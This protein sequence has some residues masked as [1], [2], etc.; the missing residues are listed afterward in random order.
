MEGGLEHDYAP[1]QRPSALTVIGA[2]APGYPDLHQSS[3]SHGHGQ[4]TNSL[5]GKSSDP[6]FKF[7]QTIDWNA[8]CNLLDNLV[9]YTIVEDFV[10]AP[11]A[12]KRSNAASPTKPGVPSSPSTATSAS[13]SSPPPS[14]PAH[15]PAQTLSYSS[16][17]AGPSATPTTAAAARHSYFPITAQQLQAARPHPYAFYNVQTHAWSILAPFPPRHSTLPPDASCVGVNVGLPPRHHYV[18]WQREVD[19]RF[20][21]RQSEINTPTHQRTHVAINRRTF[22]GPSSSPYPDP[23]STSD[24]VWFI[25]ASPETEWWDLY[26]CSVCSRAF[27]VSRPD[28][29]SSVL[30]LLLCQRFEEARRR[31]P[32]PD[33][34]DITMREALDYI[35]KVLRNL[36]YRGE[37]SAIPWTGTTFVKRMGDTQAG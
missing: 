25:Q 34:P 7:G 6:A 23:E 36:L 5:L 17:V 31:N 20:L 22:G 10:A 13:A 21:L 33:G 11:P 14:T 29:I 1:G 32:S 16:A 15:K 37:R 28:E 24:N 35:W 2:S 12:A 26:R 18:H 9:D 3:Y 30:G 8:S 4:L 19:P 27:T